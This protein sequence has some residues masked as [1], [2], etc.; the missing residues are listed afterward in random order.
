M[1]PSA[2]STSPEAQ[3]V[4][5]TATDGAWFTAMNAQLSCHRLI[6]DLR[7]VVTADAPARN[8][9]MVAHLAQC[10]SSARIVAQGIES[11]L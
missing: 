10:A 6:S 7:I 3:A 1:L 5:T 2:E 11:D 8:I 4:A 9:K